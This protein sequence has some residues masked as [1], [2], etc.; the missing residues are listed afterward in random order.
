MG[1]LV[2]AIALVGGTLVAPWPV[3]WRHQC[4]ESPAAFACVVVMCVVG[5]EGSDGPPCG[6]WPAWHNH[7][8]PTTPPVL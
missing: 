1:R 3:S 7:S 6:P 8:L 2:T 4:C 5:W